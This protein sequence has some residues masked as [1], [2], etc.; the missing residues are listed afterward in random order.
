[1]GSGR[2]GADEE[3]NEENLSQELRDRRRSGSGSEFENP[4]QNE[5]GEEDPDQPSSVVSSDTLSDDN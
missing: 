4:P 3:E 2:R 5:S 1:L